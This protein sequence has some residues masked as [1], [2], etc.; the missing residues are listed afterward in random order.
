M[1]WWLIA[2]EAGIALIVLFAV[3][4]GRK[5]EAKTPAKAKATDRKA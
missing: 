4:G 5:P 2:V 3:F 1:K